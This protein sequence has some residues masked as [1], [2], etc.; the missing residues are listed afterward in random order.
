MLSRSK[1]EYQFYRTINVSRL[2]P[3]Q[4]VRGIHLHE[5]VA[6]DPETR[7]NVTSHDAAN[8]VVGARRNLTQVEVEGVDVEL[9]SADVEV[10]GGLGV[11]G[12]REET[13]AGNLRGVSRAWNLCVEGGSGV[14]RDHNLVNCN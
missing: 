6:D 2:I 9:L 8:T 1:T 4:S 7:A 14:G 11:A 12:E 3:V 5:L 13:L 10:D